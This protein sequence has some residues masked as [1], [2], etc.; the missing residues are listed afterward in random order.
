M[1]ILLMLTGV[2]AIAAPGL[3]PAALLR[4]HPRPFTRLATLSVAV[5]LACVVVA[6]MLSV[7][8]G[9]LHLEFGHRSSNPDHLA[10]EGTVGA[11]VAAGA[12]ALIT[13][14]TTRLAARSTRMR[15]QATPDTWLGERRRGGD[16]DLTVLPTPEP[17]AFSITDRR[18][19]NVVISEGLRATLDDDTLRLV[20]DHELA[21]A[22]AHDRLVLLVARW[23]DALVPFTG[24]TSTAMRVAAER[25]ADEEA[26]GTDPVPRS[27]LAAHLARNAPMV[28]SC[29]TACAPYRADQLTRQPSR[30]PATMACAVGGL[31]ALGVIAGAVLAHATDDIGPYLALLAG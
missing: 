10:P 18:R 27:R 29:A 25:A 14:R 2:A 5:G 17:I 3:R 31:L 21:H 8:V 1:T 9:L 24:R 7:G 13:I 22:R 15:R 11:L 16:H 28:A 4:A 26:T 20:I 23:L 6:L 30:A 12:L 19:T